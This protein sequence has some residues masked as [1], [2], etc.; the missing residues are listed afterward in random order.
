MHL[1]RFYL[2][3]LF[4]LPLISFSLILRFTTW[5]GFFFFLLYMLQMKVLAYGKVQGVLHR[6][7]VVNG[8]YKSSVLL[9]TF[10]Y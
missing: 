7:H 9:P 6:V 1:P 4:V 10:T 5:R 8:P 3:R 2:S